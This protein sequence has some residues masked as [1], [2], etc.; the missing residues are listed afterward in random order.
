MTPHQL[1]AYRRLLFLTVLEAARYFAVSADYPDGCSER[2]WNRW[3]GGLAEIPHSI[4]DK[5][6]RNIEHRQ[7][8]ILEYQELIVEAARDGIPPPVAIWYHDP[9]PYANVI[10]WK[11]SRSISAAVAALG[12]RLI[13]FDELSYTHFLKSQD[14]TDTYENRQAWAENQDE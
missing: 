5:I 11:M 14:L 7:H 1:E 3:E 10:D 6:K 2:A 12:A 4:A 8:V 9:A 13:E